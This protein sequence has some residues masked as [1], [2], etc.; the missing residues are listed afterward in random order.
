PF[1]LNGVN[2][3]GIDSA[4]TPAD[5]R[6]KIWE[7]LATDWKLDNIKDMQTIVGLDDASRYLN[8]ILK[9]KTIGRVIVDLNI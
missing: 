6:L 1:I 9:G 3:L 7:K 8:K 5:I 2:L 4:Q